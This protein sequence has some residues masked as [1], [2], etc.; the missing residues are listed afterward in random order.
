MVYKL[1][2]MALVPHANAVLPVL[3]LATSHGS[4]GERSHRFGRR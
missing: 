3:T 4:N 2:S 1:A